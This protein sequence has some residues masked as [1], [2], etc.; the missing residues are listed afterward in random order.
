MVSLVAVTAVCALFVAWCFIALDRLNAKE[1]ARAARR[2]Q[3]TQDA[4]D[5]SI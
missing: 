5:D 2:I 1:R 4:F 3:A